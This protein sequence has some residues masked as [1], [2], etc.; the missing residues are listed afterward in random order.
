MTLWMNI[1]KCL[2]ILSMKSNIEA[3]L[4][5]Q[6]IKE[7][8][9]RN[10]YVVDYKNLNNGNVELLEKEPIDIKSVHLQNSNNVNVYFVGFEDNILGAGNQQCECVLFP[11]TCEE[12]DWVLFVECKYAKDKVTAKDKDR[13]YARK[14][15]DQIIATVNYFRINGVLSNKKKVHAIVSFPNLLQN[16]S[17]FVF[18]AVYPLTMEDFLEQHNIIIR[19]TNSAVIK[20][21]KM[22][23]I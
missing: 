23:K 3:L 13:D 16:F 14:M 22:I 6:K 5:Q 21:A 1:T 2:T 15:I 19:A 18:S 9:F 12:K 10:L 17:A 8:S 4:P 11:Q 7:S 20:S